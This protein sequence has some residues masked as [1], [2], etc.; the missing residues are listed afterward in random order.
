MI[1]KE[2]DKLFESGAE[3]EVNIGKRNTTIILGNT[4][5]RRHQF[6]RLLSK[7]EGKV[8]EAMVPGSTRHFYY[9]KPE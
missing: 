6:A 8:I 7:Y 3:L 4:E 2:I 5:L 1:Q 9:Y